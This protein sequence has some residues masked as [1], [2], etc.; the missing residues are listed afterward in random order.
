MV[1]TSVILITYNHE[2]YI[3]RAL[4]SVL[5]QQTCFDFEVIITEDCSTDATREIV[6]EYSHKYPDRI[7]LALSESNVCTPWVLERAII[8]ARGEYVA[9]LDGD[10]YWTS[11]HKLEKQAQFM[12]AHPEF[13]FSWH[14]VQYVDADGAP[15]VTQPAPVTKRDWT[16]RDVVLEYPMAA[17]SVVLRRSTIADLPDWYRNAPAGDFPLWVLSMRFGLAGYLDEC[18]GAYRIHAGSAVVKGRDEVGIRAFWLQTYRYVYLHVAPS[19]RAM[20][21]NHLAVRW[22]DVALCQFGKGD[23]AGSGQTAR[24]GLHDCPRNPKLLLLA[25]VPW[26]WRPVRACYRLG[27]I[28][29]GHRE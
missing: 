25:Y 16:L 7:R 27:R 23:V 3:R 17:G 24:Q 26:L 15:M 12:D 28:I 11:P 22:L 2:R 29:S 13:A 21:A 9:Y 8:A 6:L 1:K 19:T 4:D 18:L 14:A 10:D 20:M 5:S